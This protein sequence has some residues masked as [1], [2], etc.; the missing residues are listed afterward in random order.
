MWDFLLVVKRYHNSKCVLG[1]RQTQQI[2]KQTN[3]QKDSAVAYSRLPCG[4]GLIVVNMISIKI[5]RSLLVESNAVVGPFTMINDVLPWHVLMTYFI[6]TWVRSTCHVIPQVFVTDDV[7]S[8][9]EMRGVVI[10]HDHK[11]QRKGVLAIAA[12]TKIKP[13]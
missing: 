4:R 7:L 8:S 12:K 3:K 2:N 11:A 9:W 13:F 10:Y 1:D 6:M 5:R